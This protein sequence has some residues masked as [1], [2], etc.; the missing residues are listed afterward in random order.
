[1]P[2]HSLSGPRFACLVEVAWRGLQWFLDGERGPGPEAVF[3]I[4]AHSEGYRLGLTTPLLT[5]PVLPHTPSP[6]VMFIGY[7][8]GTDA[9][10]SSDPWGMVS[11]FWLSAGRE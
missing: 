3:S 8:L 4:V 6:T 2:I 5:L 9:E 1:M 11:L 10:P 7:S